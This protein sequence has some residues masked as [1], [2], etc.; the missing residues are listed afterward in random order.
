MELGTEGGHQ[1]GLHAQVLV[2]RDT[3]EEGVDQSH[4]HRRGDQL[5]IEFGT[6]GNAARDDRRDGRREGQQEE[7]FHQLETAALG[8]RFGTGKEAHAVSHVIA[9]EEIDD[10]RHRKVGQDLH[11]GIDLVLPAHPPQFQEGKA[12]MHG[13]DHDRP[14]QNE[15]GVCAV[16]VIVHQKISQKVCKEMLESHD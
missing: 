12:G 8:Q 10:G 3:F 11:Q 7:E 6:L 14:Q 13:Q 1:P 15:E 16:F 5:R 4:Q 2:P 9:D